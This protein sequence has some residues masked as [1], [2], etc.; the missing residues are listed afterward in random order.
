MPSNQSADMAHPRVSVIRR[1]V[2]RG[3]VLRKSMT[4]KKVKKVKKHFVFFVVRPKLER[5]EL[6]RE[7]AGC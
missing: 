2:F 3:R 7:D 1:L 6:Y 5:L 4:E